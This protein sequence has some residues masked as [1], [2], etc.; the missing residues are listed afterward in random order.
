MERPQGSRSRAIEEVD[1]QV[2]SK[3]VEAIS[4][5]KDQPVQLY[6]PAQLAQ[7]MQ[8]TPPVKPQID[9]VAHLLPTV[10]AIHQTLQ[11]LANNQMNEV[12]YHAP[13]SPPAVANL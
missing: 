13:V 4:P 6:K 12:P 8:P 2:S 9:V 10:M 11:Y 5:H 1:T 3:H 7:P